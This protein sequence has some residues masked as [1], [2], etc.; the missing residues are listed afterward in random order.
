MAI[1]FS[2]RSL[3]DPLEGDTIPMVIPGSSRGDLIRFLLTWP[4][5]SA[6]HSRR[7]RQ[8]R[9]P[10]IPYLQDHTPRALCC[11]VT[12]PATG[13]PPCW[14]RQQTAEPVVRPIHRCA[15]QSSRYVFV[16]AYRSARSI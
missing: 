5:E 6:S 14:R 12:T 1:P 13:S 4:S 9:R 2:S 15:W 7:L 3:L 10:S 8:K 11:H 16:P